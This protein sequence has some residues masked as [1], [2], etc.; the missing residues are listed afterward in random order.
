MRDARGG[1]GGAPFLGRRSFL[2]LACLRG[3][4]NG[5]LESQSNEKCW[6]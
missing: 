2:R 4:G 5:Q 3:R 6:V 1:G